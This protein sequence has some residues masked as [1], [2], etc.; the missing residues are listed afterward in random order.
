[1]AVRAVARVDGVVLAKLSAHGGSHALLTDAQ[2]DQPVHLVGALEL[3]D[4]LLEVADAPHRLEQRKGA[5]LAE[6]ALRTSS[7]HSYAVTGACPSTCCT[8]ST[9]LSSLGSTYSSIGCE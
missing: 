7:G 2:V 3:A 6:G 5:L 8:A 9:T 4:A 1:V